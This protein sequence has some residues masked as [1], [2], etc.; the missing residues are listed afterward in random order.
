MTEYKPNLLTVAI[1]DHHRP[2]EARKLFESLDNHLKV[3]AD[4][5]YCHDGQPSL[6]YS[7]DYLGMGKSHALIITNKPKGCGIQT[8]QLFQAAMT[9]YVM[10]VQV[11]QY[12]VRDFTEEHFAKCMEI[13]EEPHVF[14]VDLA[15]NQG[16]G[17][18]SERALLMKRQKYLD[19]PGI[20]DVI[21]GPG[22]YADHRWTEKHLQDHMTTE[23]LLFATLNPF[24]FADNGKWSRRS[25]P[26]GGITIHST[27]EKVLRILKP[28]KERYDFPNLNL[29]DA[30]WEE[31]LTGRWPA[32]GKIPEAD[33]AHSFKVPGWN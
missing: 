12:L 23:S 27:D 6:P 20:N 19:I 17:R 28:L 9:P 33:K 11:D 4:V 22:P 26:C 30:E 15:G 18:P 24:F 25:Y 13:L 16:Q 29:S 1:L 5:L 2:N 3:S 21:G 32:E 10:Y 8:R 31:V 7:L 14:Y